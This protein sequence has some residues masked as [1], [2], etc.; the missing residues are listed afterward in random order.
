MIFFNFVHD[1]MSIEF[2]RFFKQKYFQLNVFFFKSFVHV[3][4]DI[5]QI[6]SSYRKSRNR[7]NNFTRFHLKL[8]I[9]SLDRRF[10]QFC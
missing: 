10:F 9:E 3:R 1:A 4:I 8:S 6:K 7:V 2:T 5:E